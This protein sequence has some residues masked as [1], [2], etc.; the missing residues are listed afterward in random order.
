M[1]WVRRPERHPRVTRI[2]FCHH[3]G[4]HS[5]GHDQDKGW[6]PESPLHGQGLVINSQQ[7]YHRYQ[8][9]WQV[10]GEGVKGPVTSRQDSNRIEFLS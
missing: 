8:K 5:W 3:Q 7:L 10:R 9:V 2:A 6:D 1:V 4:F